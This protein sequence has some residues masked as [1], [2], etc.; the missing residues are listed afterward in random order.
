MEKSLN[1]KNYINNFEKS[2]TEIKIYI[3][4][5]FKFLLLL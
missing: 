3:N 4:I 2:L 1:Y 5:Y